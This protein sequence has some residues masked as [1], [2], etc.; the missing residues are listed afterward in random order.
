MNMVF[1]LLSTVIFLPLAVALVLTLLPRKNTSLVKVF[2]LVWTILEFGLSLPLFFN[3]NEKTAGMQFMENLPW[4]PEFGIGYT[5]GVDGISMLLVLLTTFLTVLCVL[6]SW[7]SITDKV[8]E[9]HVSF[10]LLETA[11]LGALCSL[12]LVLFYIFW[13][14]MLVPMYLI[15]GVFGG[16]NRVYAAVK[17]FLFC[18]LY[19]SDAADE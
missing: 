1:P 9:Y 18:L 13:E 6:C 14:L 7:N 8:K 17:F 5:I 15:I 16:P 11:M 10:L 4:F 19:T 2:T 3:F 12:D